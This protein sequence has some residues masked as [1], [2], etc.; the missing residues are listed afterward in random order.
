MK[1]TGYTREMIIKQTGVNLVYMV[2]RS[3]M[4]ELANESLI[5][6]VG[7]LLEN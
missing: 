5:V 2:E 3:T 7:G 1:L 6:K 4:E